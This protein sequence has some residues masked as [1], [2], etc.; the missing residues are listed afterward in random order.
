[1]NQNAN[2]GEVITKMKNRKTMDSNPASLHS[3]R[4]DEFTHSIP[5]IT[6]QP[7]KEEKPSEEE[8]FSHF[9][10]VCFTVNYLV[11]TGFLC[12]PWAFEQGGI[13]LSVLT[14]LFVVFISN[15]TMNYLLASMAVAEALARLGDRPEQK[16]KDDATGK[17][18]NDYGSTSEKKYGINLKEGTKVVVEKGAMSPFVGVL[19]PS[20][21]AVYD[22]RGSEWLI[23]EES[24]AP[25][26]SSEEIT[27]SLHQRK[28]IEAEEPHLV[29]SRKFEVTDLCRI[30]LG[31]TGE[32]MLIVFVAL[33]VYAELWAFTSVVSSSA[34]KEAPL[35]KS[36]DLDYLS[37]TAIFAAIVVPLSCLELREQVQFQITLSACR[38]LVIGI[39]ITSTIAAACA[40]Y[41]SIDEDTT[42]N[43]VVYFTDVDGAQGASLFTIGGFNA[44]F[45][46]MFYTTQ[47]HLSIPVLSSAVQD[48]RRLGSIFKD[49]LLIITIALSILGFAVAWYF[50]DL[51]EQSANLHW[52]TYVGGIRAGEEVP[53][54]AK[55]ISLFVV[56]FPALN[57]LSA[58]P[59][60]VILLGNNLMAIAYGNR[61]DEAKVSYSYHCPFGSTRDLV[62]IYSAPKLSTT[63]HSCDQDCVS[64]TSWYSSYY[65]RHLRPRTG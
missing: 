3:D 53:L 44:M 48:K 58:Y 23:N 41:E 57:I 13:V 7:V 54:S 38:L 60:N 18:D 51:V 50:G 1:V 59:L 56:C 4:S 31:T 22:T 16:E 9:I 25:S 43:E 63:G 62:S 28:V 19:G 39:M 10:A 49:S 21:R 45:S 47:F 40:S 30:Y 33:D 14:L 65:R 42:T 61:I 6:N 17:G 34:A 11:G 27:D 8:G 37:Y 35:S 24:G 26:T 55:A 12:I 20:S 2:Y 46:V 29:R 36:F 15:I 32:K 5:L 52:K 64:L